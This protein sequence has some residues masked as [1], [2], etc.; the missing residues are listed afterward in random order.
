[1]SGA[2]ETE[3]GKRP[4][5]RDQKSAISDQRSEVSES[6]VLTE[7][8]GQEG[9]L[10]IVNCAKTGYACAGGLHRGRWHGAGSAG[11]LR[12]DEPRGETDRDESPVI[13]ARG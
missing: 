6:I 3:V 11:R 1:M 5:I 4:E 13:S 10:G 8:L 9:W 12:A 7:G 2:A